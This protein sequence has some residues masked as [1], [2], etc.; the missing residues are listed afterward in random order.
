[1]LDA[2]QIP[3]LHDHSNIRWH[4]DPPV[5]D[6]ASDP[7]DPASTPLT[8]LILAQHRA[9]FDLWHEEDKAREPEASDACIAQVK[10]NIDALNQ[11]RNDL[12]EAMDRTLLEAAGQQNLAAPLHSETPGLIIDRL[13][14][15]ALKIYHTAE[16]A[17]RTSASEAHHQRNLSRLALLQ[18]QRADLAACLEALWAE[19]LSGK[20][21]FKL[22]RQMKMY[23][24]PELNPMMYAHKAEAESS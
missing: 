22:Y 24:D 16:E 4:R 11:T 13:S 14:I 15:L 7:E 20:R 9:N 21:R 6:P 2:R 10:H 3:Q 19:V 18:E 8:D 17:H 5:R 12:V 1:M 23:N